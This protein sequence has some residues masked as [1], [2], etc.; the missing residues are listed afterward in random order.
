MVRWL[1]YAEPGAP[2]RFAEIAAFIEQNP[3]WPRQKTLR[4]RAE[5]ALVGESDDD[6]RRLVQAL[7][8]G[9]RRRQ[10]ARRRDPDQPRRCRRPAPRR[11][12][13]PGSR[14]ISPP[15]DEASF[16][17]RHRRELR[18]EDHEKRL[19]RL[20]WDGQTEA[21]RR[22]L[23]LVPAGL[24]RPGRG[25]PGARRR[26]RQCRARWSP[27]SRRSCAPTR[28]SPSRRRAGGARRT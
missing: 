16:L 25:A 27:R 7:P 15:L 3:D 2:G 4:R 8:A 13:R 28:A 20:L 5:E 23:P 22:M 18:P 9:Q 12:A 26:R 10:G 17:A 24:P 1:D 14:A 19:D 21:A 11:C 6:R